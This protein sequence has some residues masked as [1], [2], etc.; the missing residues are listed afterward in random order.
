M[1]ENAPGPLL[2]HP[3]PG[4]NQGQ[5]IARSCLPFLDAAEQ[6]RP[7]WEA[8][9]ERARALGLAPPAIATTADPAL[10]IEVNGRRFAPASVQG[11]VHTFVLPAFDAAPRLLSR[12]SCPHGLHPWISDRRR[13][14][15]SVR[16]IT[17]RRAGQRE[18]LPLDHPGLRDG[19]WQPE[20]DAAAM[21]RWTNGS[22][23]LPLPAGGPAVLEVRIDPPLAYAVAA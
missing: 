3:D 10:E 14:G 19:W 9:A 15:V 6:V 4:A 21:W 13:L 1:F 16:G 18:V 22:A 7:I 23:E 2:L 8:L 20:R 11:G 17:L 5:R 12:S